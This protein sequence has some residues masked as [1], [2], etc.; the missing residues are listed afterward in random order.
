MNLDIDRL[1]PL[2]LIMNELV[3]NAVKHA[4]KNK[5]SGK[6]AIKGIFENGFYKLMVTDDGE[7]M[8]EKFSMDRTNSL[9]IRLMK[10]L[11]NQ[12]KAK[13]SIQSVSGETCFLIQIPL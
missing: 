7:G 2:G 12:I 1:V 5:T 4:F 9:G 10:G 3:T 6:I 13:I 11:A 8:P